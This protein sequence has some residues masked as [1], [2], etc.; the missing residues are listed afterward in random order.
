MTKMVGK[1]EMQ[2]EETPPYADFFVSVLNFTLKIF[3]INYFE[4]T[5]HRLVNKLMILK[6]SF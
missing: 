6:Q 5:Y 4:T 2:K 1:M 3:L